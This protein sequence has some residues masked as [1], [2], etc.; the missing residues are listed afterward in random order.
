[1]RLPLIPRSRDERE[2]RDPSGLGREGRR[3]HVVVDSGRGRGRR[4]VLVAVVVRVGGE[5][6]FPGL[7]RRGVVMLLWLLGV[8]V[9]RERS[10]LLLS[11]STG[12]LGEH[13]HKGEERR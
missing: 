7:A 3:R 8:R 1:M 13:G 9:G 5:R 10:W 12:E 4:S 6:E 2:S 11:G